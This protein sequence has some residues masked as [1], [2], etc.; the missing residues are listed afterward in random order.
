LEKKRGP[1]SASIPNYHYNTKTGQCEKF[2]YG[3]CGGNDNRFMSMDDCIQSCSCHVK[4][5]AGPCKAIKERWYYNPSRGCCEKFLYGG[6]QGNSNNFQSYEECNKMCSGSF[7]IGLKPAGLN[8]GSLKITSISGDRSM[9][10]TFGKKFGGSRTVWL[11]SENAPVL[12]KGVIEAMTNSRSV[13]LPGAKQNLRILGRELTGPGLVKAERMR[14]SWSSGPI[15]TG[16]RKTVSVSTGP[17]ITGGMRQISGQSGPLMG[18][19]GGGGFAINTVSGKSV[20][21]INPGGLK[22]SGQGG[23]ISEGLGGAGGMMSGGGFATSM[24]GG[25]GGLPSGSR[26]ATSMRGGAGGL[27]SGSGFATSMRG[28]AGG[29]PSGSRIAT[30]MRGG[31][32]GLQSGS[33]FSTGMRGGAGNFNRLGQQMGQIVV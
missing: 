16:V 19:G 29:L 5:D 15:Q 18:Q 11:H 3:G 32:G 30:N 4:P 31:A 25:A 22:I 8:W 1:C 24:R 2:M 9:G 23:L 28:G 17:V 7:T 6:C 21:R 20:N 10:G 12:G 33:G 14:K 27:Q 13:Q 26:F